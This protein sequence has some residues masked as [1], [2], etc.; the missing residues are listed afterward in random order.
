MGAFLQT[1]NPI[2]WS[3]ESQMAG[4]PPFGFGA[5]STVPRD[6]RPRSRSCSSAIRPIS[7]TFAPFAVASVLSACE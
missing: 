6:Y 2:P 3:F 5:V 4:G 1:P 7:A